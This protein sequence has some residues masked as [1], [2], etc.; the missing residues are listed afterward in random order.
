VRPASVAFA[1]APRRRERGE[2]DMPLPAWKRT[3]LEVVEAQFVLEFLILLLV[4]RWCV[5]RT[6]VHSEAVAGR[7]TT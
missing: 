3:A 4:H 1:L 5:R 6:N 2:D 7:C